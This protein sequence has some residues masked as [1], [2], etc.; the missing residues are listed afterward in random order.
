MAKLEQHHIIEVGDGEEDPG[1]I[2]LKEPSDEDWAKFMRDR[3]PVR[4]G[5]RQG[6]VDNSFAMRVWLFDRLCVKVENLA[7]ADGPI[8]E[9]W[10]ERIPSRLK[11]EMIFKTFENRDD[12]ILKN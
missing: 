6:P 7:D 11:A 4:R 8:G 12:V 1:Y 10:K 3:Y 9:D 5:G 2:T